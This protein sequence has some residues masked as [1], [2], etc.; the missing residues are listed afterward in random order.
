VQA[1]A[2]LGEIISAIE[3]FD[4]ESL[5]LVVRGGRVRSSDAR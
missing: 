3:F 5:E 4:N 1:K 2:D